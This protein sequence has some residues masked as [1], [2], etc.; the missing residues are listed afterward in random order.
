M[1]EF[2]YLAGTVR[3]TTVVTIASIAR[4]SPSGDGTHVTF[5]DGTDL[6]ATVPHST[7]RDAVLTARSQFVSLVPA[8]TQ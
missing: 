7:F 6:L 5:V 1:L 4:F 3:R 8:G 2:E